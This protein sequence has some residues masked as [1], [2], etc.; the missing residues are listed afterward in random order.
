ML[1]PVLKSFSLLEDNMPQSPQRGYIFTRR[2]P[3]TM[4]FTL[5]LISNLEYK[6]H[7]GLNKTIIVPHVLGL[8]THGLNFYNDLIFY[9]QIET[10]ATVKHHIF[11][12]SP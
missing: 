11:I 12:Q 10:I 5:K 7:K 9:N 6:Y 4:R 2:I 8:C 3:S 1:E